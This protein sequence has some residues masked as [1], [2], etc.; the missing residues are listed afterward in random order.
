MPYGAW[1][2]LRQ[3]D[4]A[5]SNKSRQKQLQIKKPHDNSHGALLLEIASSTGFEPVLLE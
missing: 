5:V 4:A 3:L 1:T 2:L